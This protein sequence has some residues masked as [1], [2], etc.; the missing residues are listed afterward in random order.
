[1]KIKVIKEYDDSDKFSTIVNKHIEN[2]WE[3][4]GEPKIETVVTK[5]MW[6]GQERNSTVHTVYHQVLKTKN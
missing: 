3:L 1:M 6:D 2:G 5:N 4:F